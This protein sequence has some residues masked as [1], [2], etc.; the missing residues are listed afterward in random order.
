MIFRIIKN[1]PDHLEIF[2][3]IRKLP[4]PSGHL[5]DN[6]DTFKTFQKLS[7]LSGNFPDSL[8]IFQALQKLSRP[9][10]KYPDYPEP[11]QA[12]QKLSRLASQTIQTLSRLSKNIPDFPETFQNIRT[13]SRLPRNIPYY[14]ETSQCNFKGCA[15]KLS[16]CNA[17]MPRW[18]WCLWSHACSKIINLIYSVLGASTMK[19]R[20]RDDSCTEVSSL[21]LELIRPILPTVLLSKKIT[22]TM[23]RNGDNYNQNYYDDHL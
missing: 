22:S 18:F 23:R 16:R 20:W 4:R 1:F 6:P 9:S 15:Q 11:F 5:T 7:R 19:E 12:I 21:F 2:Q 13:L 8:E 3:M 17:T 14:P 10:G